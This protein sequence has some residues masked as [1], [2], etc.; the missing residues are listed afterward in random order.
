MLIA[1]SILA[2]QRGITQARI[3]YCFATG[4][5]WPLMAVGRAQRSSARDDADGAPKIYHTDRPGQ[6]RGSAV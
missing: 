3:S 2:S 4:S 6:N 5:V 1:L